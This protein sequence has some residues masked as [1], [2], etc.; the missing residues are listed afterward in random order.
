MSDALNDPCTLERVCKM[1]HSIILMLLHSTSTP[2]MT[3]RI[4]K[5]ST[6]HRKYPETSKTNSMSQSPCTKR[7]SLQPWHLPCNICYSSRA[8]Q[9]SHEGVTAGG[10]EPAL[11][12]WAQ[13]W[14]EEKQPLSKMWVWL[15]PSKALIFTA[16]NKVQAEE[17]AVR[18]FKRCWAFQSTSITTPLPIPLC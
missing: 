12:L 13:F 6:R 16:C 2:W 11:Y 17:F 14:K 5:C 1:R 9:E 10:E 15:N 8:A 3:T 7:T 4:V 18:T